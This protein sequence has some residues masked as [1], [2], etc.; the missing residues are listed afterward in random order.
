M[1]N[2]DDT[3]PPYSAVDEPLMCCIR[4]D[5]VPT[6]TVDCKS[7]LHSQFQEKYSLAATSFESSYFARTP[8]PSPCSF[9]LRTRTPL[10]R[11]S[12]VFWSRASL[13]IRSRCG[14][15]LRWWQGRITAATSRRTRRRPGTPRTPWCSRR[16]GRIKSSRYSPTPCRGL[17]P[18]PQVTWRCRRC[19][20]R[21][22]NCRRCRSRRRH[23]RHP[24]LCMGPRRH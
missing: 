9:V 24:G 3:P 8:P 15:I 22:R 11:C 4:L 18:R 10:P 21:C 12:H 14:C 13:L 16:S 17:G 20:R 1:D 5:G 19:R 23:P 6:S 7:L 2:D